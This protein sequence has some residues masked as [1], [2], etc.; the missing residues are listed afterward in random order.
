MLQKL[1]QRSGFSFSVNLCLEDEGISLQATSP[2]KLDNNHDAWQKYLGEALRQ[3]GY[4]PYFYGT[5]STNA[6]ITRFFQE[7]AH[8]KN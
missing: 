5:W 3:T 8:A 1:Y 2:I 4:K 6:Q 7:K